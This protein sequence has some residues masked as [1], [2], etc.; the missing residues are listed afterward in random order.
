MGDRR[1]ETLGDLV[2][3][4][5]RAGIALRCNGCGR[6]GRYLASDV[7]AVHGRH[8]FVRDLRFRCDECKSVYIAITLERSVVGQP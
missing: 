1:I 2:H 4:Y 7:S 3:Y 5:P 6:I 8:R